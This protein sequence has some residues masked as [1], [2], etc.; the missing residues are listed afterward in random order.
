MNSKI[1]KGIAAGMAASMMLSAFC[2][3]T[4]AADE[5]ESSATGNV[6]FKTFV[7]DNFETET[8]TVFVGE[9]V[10]TALLLSGF[11]K[12]Y[13]IENSFAWNPEELAIQSVDKNGKYVDFG[14]YDPAQDSN[15]LNEDNYIYSNEK[16]PNYAYGFGINESFANY[17]YTLYN[18][19]TEEYDEY[20]DSLT[21][22]KAN[23]VPF[24]NTQEGNLV[25]GWYFNDNVPIVNEMEYMSCIFKPQKSG[26]FKFGFCPYKT[27]PAGV[28]ALASIKGVGSLDIKVNISDLNTKILDKPAT[29]TD[30]I[31]DGNEATWE[32]SENRGFVVQLYKDGEKCGDEVALEAD[33]KA[34]D[35]SSVINAQKGDATY[36]YTVVAKGGT[37]NSDE[38]TSN[39]NVVVRKLNKPAAP[40][41]DGSKLT[42]NTVVENAQTYSVQLY[43]DG[44]KYGNLI[45]VDANSKQVD[46]AKSIS[47][48]GTYTATVVAKADGYNDSEESEQTETAFATGSNIEGTFGI[49]DG[50]S[51]D[52]NHPKFIVQNVTISLYK[53]NSIVK[54]ATI[55]NDTHKFTFNNV[56]EG[57][58][59]LVIEG[60]CVLKRIY[61][62]KLS[63]N[64]SYQIPQNIE[65]VYG[66]LNGDGY[67]T[68]RDISEV[69]GFVNVENPSR[70]YHFIDSGAGIV[71]VSEFGHICRF[72]NYEYDV[73][74]STIELK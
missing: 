47:E 49:L 64:K 54:K 53:N 69:N 31:W 30:V 57:D 33:V 26:A 39:E 20:E 62:L 48:P 59:K 24:T 35:F 14:G 25:F 18:E 22:L 1:V 16:K 68:L 44:I 42:W 61:D 67:I 36:T 60:N 70:N 58:Y 37:N 46:L 74:E 50:L 19:I 29:P 63:G 45:D 5:G 4:Y 73:S 52:A 65:F 71:T 11:D 72:Y 17:K 8:N 10:K 32:S 55:D 51:T 13:G 56:L 7:G 23:G 21:I 43:K 2:L 66:D 41:W 34:Y 38:A 15:S 40:V 12:L 27:I 6:V 28:S 3:T 9:N